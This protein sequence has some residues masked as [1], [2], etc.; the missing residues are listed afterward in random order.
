MSGWS[1]VA[2]IECQLAQSAVLRDF[3]R[4]GRHCSAALAANNRRSG[5]W[6]DGWVLAGPC[7]APGVLWRARTAGWAGSRVSRHG[8]WGGFREEATGAAIWP[9]GR[10]GAGQ[11]SAVS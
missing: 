8:N 6:D 2:W 9:L 7:A 11:R 1:Q 10:A 5:R 4:F 3:G